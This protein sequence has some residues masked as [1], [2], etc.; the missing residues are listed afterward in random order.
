LLVVDRLISLFTQRDERRR[1]IFKEIIEPLF[2][3]LETVD[4]D[5]MKMFKKIDDAAA[6]H[7]TDMELRKATAEY[8]S[9]RI[10]MASMREK[11]RELAEACERVFGTGSCGIFSLDPFILFSA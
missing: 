10:A 1:A 4:Q 8:S 5:Y 11:L 9:E 2:K 6:S 3:D 7:E